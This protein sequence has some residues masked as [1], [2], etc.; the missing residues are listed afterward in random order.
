MEVALA[1]I[2]KHKALLAGQAKTFASRF[3]IGTRLNSEEDLLSR[4]KMCTMR[5]A[6]GLPK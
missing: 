4:L 6:F 5:T 3:K 2:E 1:A